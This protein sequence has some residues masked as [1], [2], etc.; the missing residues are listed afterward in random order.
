MSLRIEAAQLRHAKIVA[1]SMRARDFEEVMA[2]WGRPDIAI[3]D[4]IEAS[5]CY[6][7]TAFWE[8]EP[9]AIFGMRS[10]TVLGGSAEVWCFGTAAIDRHRLAFLRASR[11][12][13][14]DMLTRAAI[15]TNYVDITDYDALRWLAW[16]GAR[17]ALPP[18]SRGG[19]LFAQFFISKPMVGEQTCQLG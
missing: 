10:L 12:V 6:S 18:Q 15:L 7:R 8:L 11:L 9:V 19:K 16:V 2:G 4:A 14:A 1:Q 5:P 3:I 17:S 13:V